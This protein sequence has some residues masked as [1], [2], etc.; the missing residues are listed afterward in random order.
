MFFENWNREIRGLLEA[1]EATKLKQGLVITA[2][3][4]KEETIKGKKIRFVPL[5]KWLLEEV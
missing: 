2:D 5:W 4:E 1:L 3:K